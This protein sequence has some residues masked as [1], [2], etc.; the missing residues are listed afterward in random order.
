MNTKNKFSFLSNADVVWQNNG[1]NKLWPYHKTFSDIYFSQ[2]D[3]YQ[4]SL[5]VFL[6]NGNICEYI[7]N[8]NAE[9]FF[10]LEI[11]FGFALNFCALQE[12][13]EQKKIQKEI[14][15]YSCEKYPVTKED[16]KKFSLQMPLLKNCY[17]F[18][19]ASYPPLVEGWYT[20][21]F[22]PQIQL[23]LFWGD[24]TNFTCFLADNSFDFVF[25]DGHSPAKNPHLWSQS[26]L[27][28]LAQ[29][30]KSGGIIKSFSVAGAL[31]RNLIA[32]DF[33]V[34]KVAGN[35][36]KRENLH[37]QK[38]QHPTSKEEHPQELPKNFSKKISTCL[39]PWYTLPHQKQNSPPKKVAIIGGGISGCATAW[40]LLQ[41][42]Y[43]V[44]LIEQ[45]SAFAAEASG[46]PLGIV[47][48][49]AAAQPSPLALFSL[50]AYHYL[51]QLL[52]NFTQNDMNFAYAPMRFY[53][54]D[55]HLSSFV[56][57]ATDR[58]T[59]KW[60]SFQ[61]W[62]HNFLQVQFKDT[63]VE[64]ENCLWLSPPDFSRALL[65]KALNENQ[66]NFVCKF[67]SKVQSF[68]QQPDTDK[69]QL[70]ITRADNT[71]K[72]WQQEILEYDAVVLAGGK[73]LASWLSDFSLNLSGGHV[74][75]KKAEIERNTPA[76]LINGK[77]YFIAPTTT[78]S[79]KLFLGGASFTSNAQTHPAPPEFLQSLNTTLKA[80]IGE[81][82]INIECHD[83][84]QRFSVRCHS[85]DY[86]PIVGPVP[87]FSFYQKNYFDLQL[88]KKEQSYAE[89]RYQK[90]LFVI[91]GMGSKGMLWAPLAAKL[92]KQIIQQE[93]L[94]ITPYI[95]E[96]LHPARFWIRSWLRAKP[97]TTDK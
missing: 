47:H 77:H 70:Q 27:Q 64:I 42:G 53:A 48:P 24:V 28:I 33:V 16:L 96:H 92:L 22:T 56:K 12:L 35:G 52:A 38:K 32:A 20:I 81:K 69:W 87:D 78:D 45:H 57:Q 26:L 21:F 61:N 15:Y 93:S 7:K 60:K 1:N 2:E 55:N 86:L 11:G 85:K 71:Q 39:P 41:A 89:A 65:Q 25:L 19:C 49:L 59:K 91:G 9:E 6:E 34:Q 40:H 31:R 79:R 37:A 4:E 29:K 8:S 68:W 43:H 30:T 5:H 62:N 10:I 76:F 84:E 36:K 74:I 80:I 17:D 13:V 51:Q 73:S 46:N 58:L 83:F 95:Y 63:F 23:H 67:S 50:Y 14:H 94:T 75:Y 3:P 82:F 97:K 72:N 18:L 44:T 54:N 66:E 90:N 88:G